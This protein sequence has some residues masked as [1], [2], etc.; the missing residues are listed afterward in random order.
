[1]PRAEVS[2]GPA[3]AF[4]VHCL[5]DG[6]GYALSFEVFPAA[7]A[8]SSHHF[9]RRKHGISMKCPGTAERAA[10]SPRQ[11]FSFFPNHLV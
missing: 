6:A 3:W 4:R 5:T 8:A 1:M 11:A 7:L 10:R 2:D 9:A